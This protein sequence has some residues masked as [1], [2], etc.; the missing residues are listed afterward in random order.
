MTLFEIG[1]LLMS[2]KLRLLD[3]FCGAGGASMGYHRAGFEVEGVDNRPQ[4]N[5]PFKFYQAD[6][7][8]F[9]GEHGQEYDVIHASPPCQAYSVTKS[10]HKRN[11]PD[12]VSDTRALL[13][14]IGKPYIIENVPGS[15]LQNF[16]ILC[17]SMFPG[18]RV[19]R[20]RHFECNPEIIFPPMCCNHSF[21]MPAS[22]GQYHTLEKYE[23]ITCVG[24]NFQAKSGRIAMGIDW[25][26]RKELSQAIPPAY[27]EWIGKELLREIA[28][29]P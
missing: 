23:R 13:K 28:A 1:G 14:K 2:R 19:Y 24:N 16:V 5:Y 29:I 21:P 20:H 15:P 3:L 12:M 7:F 25:M 8:E 6:A 27:T 4:K 11:H 18:L 26:T 10:L 22:K 17:G 9:L